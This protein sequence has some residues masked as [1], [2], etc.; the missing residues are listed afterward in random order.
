MTK[1]FNE[2]ELPPYAILSH[3][4]GVN[5]VLFSDLPLLV[6][7]EE[8]K[9][10]HAKVLAF[11]AKARAQGFQYAWIDTCCI[12]KSSTVELSEAINSMYRWYQKAGT[13]FAYLSDYDGKINS[14][15]KCR[16]FKRGWTLQELIAPR[17]IEFYDKGWN[18][19]GTK[20]QLTHTLSTI[21]GIKEGVLE[22]ASPESCSIAERMSW[23]AGRETARKEDRAYSL[24]GLFD[25]NLPLIYGASDT[26]N[27]FIL[28]Q[29][30]IIKHS[31]D[32]TIFVWRKG[33][34]EQGR[35]HCGLLASSPDAFA[36]CHG[37]IQS[38]SS[39]LN[40]R[41]FGLTNVGL[42][43][44]VMI[45][46]WSIHT[47]LAMFDCMYEDRPRYRCGIL[48]ERL[49][50]ENQYARVG[51]DGSADSM[52]PF[53]SFSTSEKREIC[54]QQKPGPAVNQRYGFWIRKIGLPGFSEEEL[55]QMEIWSRAC[56]SDQPDEGRFVE[57]RPG[58]TGTVGMVYIPLVNR[59][60]TYREIRW[61]KVAFDGDFNPV[62]ILGNEKSLWGNGLSDFA[63]SQETLE[64]A[65]ASGSGSAAWSRLFNSEWLRGMI[66]AFP[67]KFGHEFDEGLLGNR[68]SFAQKGKR[69][70]SLYQEI[71]DLNIIVSMQLERCPAPPHEAK[72]SPDSS[73]E[74]WT[75]DITEIKVRDEKTPSVAVQ[76]ITAAKKTMKKALSIS[77]YPEKYSTNER[78][79]WSTRGAG[80]HF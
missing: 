62:Y 70:H 39:G 22:G 36:G 50:N 56:S 75:I 11:C 9:P 3:T 60:S 72:E 46:P 19:F 64:A 8:A 45:R 6:T 12:D 77:M 65:V 48:I 20:S 40:P 47:Y 10:V 55:R 21:T 80:S 67:R 4:W 26:R 2:S 31:D 7:S 41:G 30:E 68:G 33:S 43:L 17:E 34:S 57:I 14:L 37:I 18:L 42:V 13:C 52:G 78:Y 16:W 44:T 61:L 73:W 63:S 23:A 51:L 28:L 25:A 54:V 69:A 5:E 27:A 74:I 24:L 32:Q 59:H 79:S 49:A 15:Q 1:E 58:S 53:K 35:G 71:F 29:E 38:P 76:F 66:Y